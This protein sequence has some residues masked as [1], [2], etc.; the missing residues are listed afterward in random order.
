VC[1]DMRSRALSAATLRS[2]TA[3]TRPRT[4]RERPMRA[5]FAGRF[6]RAGGRPAV[7]GAS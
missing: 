2:T 1:N 3:S 4:G 6:P 5:C 7:T